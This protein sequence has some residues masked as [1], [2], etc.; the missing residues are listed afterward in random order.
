MRSTRSSTN[1]HPARP[2]CPA[3]PASDSTPAAT[4]AAASPRPTPGDTKAPA[5]RVR[6]SDIPASPG[7]RAYLIE[8]GLE[9]D[10]NSALNALIADYV[11]CRTRHSRYYAEAL[12]M[13][14]GD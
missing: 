9:Q 4:L 14:S 11:L 10:G 5:E 13:P 12:V 1:R 8:R 3:P 7:G 6:V 2:A